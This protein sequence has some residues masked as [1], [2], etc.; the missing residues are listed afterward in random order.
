MSESVGARYAL[1]M[2]DREGRAIFSKAQRDAVKL[3]TINAERSGGNALGIG[4][5]AA[6]AVL[7][8]ALKD[9]PDP[10][11]LLTDGEIRA[12]ERD[13][14][15]NHPEIG[16]FARGVVIEAQHAR[17]RWNDKLK[18]DFDWSAVASYLL[19]K[20]LLNP[21]QND[22]TAGERARLHRI[23]ALAALCANWHAAVLEK[24]AAKENAQ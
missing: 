17:L 8:A 18:R 22:G 19:A 24:E 20:A 5:V 2:V 13:R 6:L 7:D 23:V 21:P 16:D 10:S 4:T 12:D 14:I 15:L 11:P 9:A 3:A 1:I